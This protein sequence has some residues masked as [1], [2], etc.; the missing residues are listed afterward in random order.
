MHKR[1]DFG[2]R[3][4]STRVASGPGVLR[5]MKSF[6]KSDRP[7]RKKD[8]FYTSIYGGNIFFCR[9][10]SAE[11]KASRK[12]QIQQHPYRSQHANLDKELD[13]D[14]KIGFLQTPISKNLPG[15]S[16]EVRF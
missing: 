13:H 3:P 15:A 12:H 8:L 6:R 5:L 10:N 14:C 4:A 9:A 1:S 2:V 16:I 11:L 7:H